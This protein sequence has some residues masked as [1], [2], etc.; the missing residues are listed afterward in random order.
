MAM[1]R[2]FL[3]ACGVWGA[4]CVVAQ[5]DRVRTVDGSIAG[6]VVGASRLGVTVER[7]GTTEEAPI[8]LLISVIYSDEPAELSQARL[9]AENG[10][11]ESA[12]EKLDAINA[13]LV[14][15]E[16]VRQDLVYYRAYCDARLAM[17]GKSDMAS[18]A[19]ALQEFAKE[20]PDSHHYYAVVQALGD[21]SRSVDRTGYAARMYRMLADSESAAV[22]VR[23]G[24]LLGTMLQEGGDHRGAIEALD[25][26]LARDNDTAAAPQRTQ[27]RLVKGA[28]LAATGDLD[29][30][31]KLV[32]GV[33]RSAAADDDPLRAETYNALARCYL[34]AERPR[35]ALF[36]LLFVDTLYSEQHEQH[37]EALYRLARVWR[38]AGEAEEAEAARDT[39]RRRYAQ[40]TWARRDLSD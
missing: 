8:G 22:A 11:F 14:T 35:D 3:I 39:L 25:A 29:E 10:A 30:G 15:D 16:R 7:N 20:N 24:V 17:A 2:A 18:A 1:L 40:T 4:A 6:E 28:S 19:R 36:A 38:E 13:S 12:I 26:A 32:R 37:A 5:G 23:G 21:L 31:L 34:A 33:M 9:A 27:A